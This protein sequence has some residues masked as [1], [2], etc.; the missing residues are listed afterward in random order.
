MLNSPD[1]EVVRR[2]LRRLHVRFWHAPTQRLSELLRH[3]GAPSAAMDKVKGIVDTCRV[4]RMWT[5]PGPRSM[6]TT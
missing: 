2:T 3:A 1:D 5:R 4:C 6:T